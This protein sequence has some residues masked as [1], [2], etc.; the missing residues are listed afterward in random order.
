M[1]IG[2]F[3]SMPAR[4]DKAANLG[5]IETVARSASLLGT[6]LVVFSELFLTRYN[7]G[8]L[9]HELAEPSDGPSIVRVQEIAANSGCAIAFGYPERAGES[10]YNSMA[11]VDARGNLAG[12]YRK[13]QL[14][15]DEETKLFARGESLV[16]CTLGQC[17]LGLGI[18]YDIEF[19]EFGRQFASMGVDIAIIPT[20]NMA[21]YWE[22]PKSIIRARAVENGIAIVYANQC[23][24]DGELEYTGMS[25]I[26]GPDGIDMARAG[27]QSESLLIAEVDITSENAADRRSSQLD[28]L[29]TI[30]TA[31]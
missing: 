31:S 12:H 22:V 25:C 30:P 26:V 14:F 13:I 1:K 27:I 20:A 10:V 21:P 5:T 15:G 3:Q 19:P 16:T 11:L 6:D 17:Q 29:S 2:V 4:G 7:I 28:D 8:N 24:H 23:G 9:C 18:C